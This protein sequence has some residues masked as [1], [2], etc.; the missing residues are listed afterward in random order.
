MMD[1][2][3]SELMERGFAPNPKV[4]KAWGQQ[5]ARSASSEGKKREP[6]G[7]LFYDDYSPPIRLSLSGLLLSRARLRFTEP[8]RFH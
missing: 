1:L 7:S 4:F 8:L 6:K 2:F 5:I 3:F